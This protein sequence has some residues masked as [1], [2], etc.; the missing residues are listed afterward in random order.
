ML[1]VVLLIASAIAVLAAISSGRVAMESRGQRTMEDEARALNEAFARLHFAINIVDNSA[2]NDDNRNLALK[3][4]MEGMHG[5]TIAGDAAE[6]EAWMADPSG[7][8]YGKLEDCDVRVYH[9]RDYIPRLEKL[10]GEAVQLDLDPSHDTRA[11]YV[12]EATG[13]AGDA[14]R[15]VSALIRENEPFSSFVFFQNRHPL[16]ISGSPRGLIHSND[17][18]DF[19]FANGDFQD[20]V[21]AVNGFRYQ[22]GATSENTNIVDGNAEA[23]RIDLE[24]VDFDKLKGEASLF[25]GQPG[26]DAEIQFR[27]NGDIRIRE[28]TKPRVDLV[29]QTYE[30]DVIDHYETETR[31]EMQSIQVGTTTEERTRNN[32]VYRSEEYTVEVPVYEDREVTRTRNIPIYEDRVVTRTR[33]V[34]VF[35]PYDNGDPQGGTAV[36]GGGGALGEWRWVQEPYETVESVVVRYETEEYQTTEPVQV[37]TTTQTRT[38]NVIDYYVEETYTVEV[39]VFEQQ[40][41]T[42]EVQ[43]PVYRT[44]SYTVEEE[45]Y[46]PPSLVEEHVVDG[47]DRSGTIYIDGRVTKL[48]G[49]V[50]TR[51]TL[52]ANEKVRITGN[53]RYV[54]D[55]GDRA[56]SGG[57]DYTETY[58]RNTDYDGHSVLGILARDDVLFTNALPN[59]SEIN[60]TL[61]SV[62]G[63]VGI[64]GFAISAEGN[65]D[66]NWYAGLSAA[67][68]RIEEAYDQG[69]YRT[70]RFRKDSLRRIGGVISND[71]IL[72][73]Y[74]RPSSDGTATVDA[75]FRRGSMKFDFNLL[76][77]PPPSFV[78][79]PRPVVTYFTPV[80]F[81]RGE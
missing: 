61:M 74:I 77:N 38:R 25:T 81:S 76:F 3:A 28:Y 55:D 72:E 59:Q 45:V 15:L 70:R 14:T 42:V 31:T 51:A 54:D 69:P 32:P 18:V 58:T 39:P 48:A 44:E 75:G 73:T 34:Q 78:E 20:P 24:S 4:A 66:K 60:A 80:Y 68:R 5:G 47:H 43:V 37:G 8:E 6:G 63:R 79:V 7:V 21:S 62:E 52:V 26:L 49:D 13:R 35:V 71:R 23:Q 53:L 22:S 41:V 64:D 40:E 46:V 57:S 1:S 11:W 19:Y 65:P 36:G 9:A 56:M 29:E 17:V 10:R 2:Y 33:W 16:G 30:Y 27:A 67:E 50:N 12:L